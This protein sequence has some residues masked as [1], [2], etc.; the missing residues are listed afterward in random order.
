MSSG[1]QPIALSDRQA[2]KSKSKGP[3]QQKHRARN[4]I[5]S[6]SG[7]V[8]EQ[9]LSTLV[10]AYLSA[11]DLREVALVSNFFHRL[12]KVSQL[13]LEL[14]RNDFSIPPQFGQSA[15]LGS[16]G[17]LTN[18]DQSQ[19][20]ISEKEKYA[21]RLKERKERY[22]H[23]KELVVYQEKER[24]R[25]IRVRVVQTFLDV[26][27]Y[28]IMVVLPIVTTF[29][30]MILFALK[31][32]GLDISIWACA[33]PLLFYFVYMFLSSIIACLVY[34]QRASANRVFGGM[35]FDL[36][37]P[38]KRLYADV[39]NESPRM[40]RF[41]ALIFYLCFMQIILVAAKLHLKESA[42]QKDDDA[43]KDISAQFNWAIVFVP[44]WMLLLVFCISPLVGCFRHSGMALFFN[45]G[46]VVW[47]PIVIVAVCLTV[48]LNGQD[49]HT[50]AGGMRLA[51]IFIPF[52]FVEGA[53][54]I[55]GFAFLCMGLHYLR[56]G[57]VDSINEHIGVFAGTWLLVGPLIMFQALLCAKDDNTGR[58]YGT[59][60]TV[61]GILSPLLILVG[62]F[63]L[64]TLIY[65]C[66]VRTPF[67]QIRE[68]SR[69]EAAGT[70]V[71]FDV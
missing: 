4:I 13:W 8:G 2:Q 16:I 21:R 27:Q 36:R 24:R 22:E 64:I 26:T 45:L 34:K 59:S 37:G 41:T 68:Q 50:D 56:L 23:A 58:A 67:Q 63:L 48:K 7:G 14:Q 35:W 30:S 54:M 39:L 69:R 42:Q 32:D 66:R 3:T 43:V 44:I 15:P 51:L 19:E 5:F 10:F 38:L 62:W 70:T 25:L 29:A 60:I 47:I 40:A 6:S 53:T 11:S 46:L 33:A 52:W 18:S 20:D 1:Y 28:R 9:L 31:Y 17:A 71:L 49:A 55:A 65:V 61:G 57:F 12:S